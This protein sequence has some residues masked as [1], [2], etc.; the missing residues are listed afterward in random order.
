MMKK[1]ILTLALVLTAALSANAQLLYKI[2]GNG[3]NRDSYIIGTYHLA[4]VS[5]VDSIP[6]INTAIDET[7]QVYG[8]L[9]MSDMASSEN[10]MKMQQA[11]MLEDGKTLSS[12][13]TEEQQ[14]KLNA[15]LNNIL[16]ADLTN[17]MLK[18]QLDKLT[19]QAMGTQLTLL[20]Y[21]KREPSFNPTKSFDGYFQDVAKEKGKEVKGFET[22]DFQIDALFH[23]MTLERQVEQLICFC[24]NFDYQDSMT[25][26][27]IKAFYAQ[28][29]KGIEEITDEKLN[30]SCDNTDEENERLIYG[31]NDNWLAQMPAIM[32]E[33]PTLFVVGAAHLVGDRG[34][35]NGLRK[36]GFTVTGVK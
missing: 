31:R 23:G 7:E 29:M 20:N 9:E 32:K 16:G 12:L 19:P 11:M 8:E 10:T 26:R 17:P 34:V 18:Q 5:F 14:G 30:N 21:L 1:T 25:E 36:A 33:K 2:S 6:G 15:I 35:L 28:D 13:L 24:D 27:L 3:I 4:Q 22:I